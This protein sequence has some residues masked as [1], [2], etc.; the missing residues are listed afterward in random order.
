MVNS[1]IWALVT[2]FVSRIMLHLRGVCHS[3]SWAD[4]MTVITQATHMEWAHNPGSDKSPT[5][6]VR[7]GF[8]TECDLYSEEH[9]CELW[10]TRSRRLSPC[11]RGGIGPCHTQ[12]SSSNTTCVGGSTGCCGEDIELDDLVNTRKTVHSPKGPKS[13][14]SKH[15]IC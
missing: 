6:I 8:N 1:I 2:A 15:L 5:Q 10:T 14:P 12:H 7:Q 11:S 13:G 4:E 3:S 9:E